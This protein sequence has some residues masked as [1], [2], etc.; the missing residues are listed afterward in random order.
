MGETDTK[1]INHL[2]VLSPGQEGLGIRVY[3]LKNCW[4]GL[5][6]SRSV[7]L[8]QIFI[9][10]LLHAI[11]VLSSAETVPKAPFPSISR[12][13]G[14]SSQG[15]TAP[16]VVKWAKADSTLHIYFTSFPILTLPSWFQPAL[17]KQ[18][19]CYRLNQVSPRSAPQPSS[20]EHDLI[21]K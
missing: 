20:S 13:W 12:T 17:E 6:F 2:H 11:I 4:Y 3:N 9:E 7:L 16:L 1:F 21:W 19:E 14:S 10:H 15:I 5:N 8:Q 18:Q